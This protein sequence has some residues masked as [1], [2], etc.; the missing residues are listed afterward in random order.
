M[1]IVFIDQYDLK[2]MLDQFPGQHEAGK[3]CTDDHYPGKL[4]LGNVHFIWFGAFKLI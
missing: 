4:T 1:I 3:S 2:G